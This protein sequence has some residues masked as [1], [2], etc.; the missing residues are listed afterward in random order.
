M[1]EVTPQAGFP[2]LLVVVFAILVFHGSIYA[3]MGLNMGWRFGYWVAGSVFGGFM[4]FMSFFW[5]TNALGPRGEEPIY[6]PLE[7]SSSNIASTELGGK[8]FESPS[9][10]PS[11]SWKQEAASTRTCTYNLP[12]LCTTTNAQPEADA[13]KAA[14]ANCLT[15]DE[16]KVDKVKEEIVKQS[17][18]TRGVLEGKFGKKGRMQRELE[19]CE[20]ATSLLPASESVPKVEGQP[21]AVA[22]DIIDVRFVREGGVLLAQAVVQPNTYD[23]RITGDPSG[24]KP[25]PVGAPLHL[26]AY[27]DT[28]SLRY[29]SYVYVLGSLVF[30]AFHLWGLNRAERRKLSPLVT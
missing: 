24:L 3:V 23:K 28:G 22:Y 9:Q 17:G 10:Y 30:F 29:P 1:P 4:V 2:A 19:A 21:A 25:Q 20:D 5:L 8:S 16:T 18:L 14:A 6:Y 11:G 15:F 7:A 13:F 27:K 26:L 12:F